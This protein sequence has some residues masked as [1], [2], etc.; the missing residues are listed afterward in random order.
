MEGIEEVLDILQDIADVE[1]AELGLKKACA[2]VEQSAK[3]KAP[4]NT[5]ELRR[6]ITSQIEN[7]GEE[8]R[9]IVYTPLLYA[10]YVE[11][12]TGLF[13]TGEAGGREDVPWCYKDDEGNWHTTSGMKPQ[14]YLNPALDE[15]REEV[16]KLI[17]EALK[18]RG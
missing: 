12:G 17:R 1:W 5:G 4:N 16:I 9:G 13:A 11:F 10:P 18:N 14:P 3:E 7:D 2:L 15:N 8:L 6:S